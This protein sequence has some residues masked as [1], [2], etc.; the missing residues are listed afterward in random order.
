MAYR[1][2]SEEEAKEYALGIPGLFEQGAQL[3]SR[4]IGDG[5]L[6][7]VFHLQD[8]KSDRSVI[9]KQALPYARVVGESWP[10][11]L[12]RARIE[13]EALQLQHEILPG[14]VPKV[15]HFDKELSLTIMED[16]SDH[17]ILRKGLI[18]AKTYPEFAKH[19]GHFIAHTTFYQ[20]DF[21]LAPEVKK[22]K[23]AEF[24][25]PDLCK[26]TEDLVFTDPYY[27][28]EKNSFNPLIEEQVKELWVNQE[29]KGQVAQLK[30]KFLTAT[31]ALIH[32]DLH[33][34]SIFVTS[35]STKVI[36]PEF[37]YFGPIGFDIGAVFANFVLN[38]AAQEVRIKN[39][40]QRN[41]YQ[42]YLL[43]SIHQIW[44]VFEQQFTLLS[45]SQAT[46]PSLRNEAFVQQFIQQVKED[47][48]GF[49]GCKVIRR[50]VGL[51]HVADL[52]TIV[53]DTERAYA[54]KLS[55]YVGQQLILHRQKWAKEQSIS[56]P[57]RS[58]FQQWE[59]KQHDTATRFGSVG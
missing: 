36:D 24:I 52:D 42:Q 37:A 39:V 32:G 5:N 33:T 57:I 38:F 35:A 27:N 18:E 54:E 34:G 20:S 4:E 15:Y 55:L 45:L 17:I 58:S 1:A 2:L 26:I 41:V 28:A 25:N 59:E 50:V 3:T 51:A 8:K 12:D 31:E 23:L 19:I 49:A 40:E 9:F 16:L 10:L 46:D 29:L 7:L 11:S 13:S 6:N 30:Y 43:E 47:A 21:F 14:L 22:Q 48:L 56:A 44:D 53:D